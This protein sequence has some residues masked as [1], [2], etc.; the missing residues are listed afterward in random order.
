MLDIDG[1][2]K[3]SKIIAIDNNF[4]KNIVGQFYPNPSQGKSFV[5]ITT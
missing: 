4:E 2:Y 1:K 3:Y 5:E